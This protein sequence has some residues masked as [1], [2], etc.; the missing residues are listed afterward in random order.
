MAG[1]GT[2]VLSKIL[3]KTDTQFGFDLNRTEDD[4]VFSRIMNVPSLLSETG[5]DKLSN[6]THLLYHG[7]IILTTT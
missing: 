6:L 5:N 2:R 7:K 4:V 1:S 3:Q